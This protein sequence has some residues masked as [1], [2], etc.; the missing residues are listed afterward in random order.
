PKK[1]SEPEGTETAD[2]PLRYMIIFPC[3]RTSPDR[4]RAGT[5]LQAPAGQQ[6]PAE[7]PNVCFSKTRR[8]RTGRTPFVWDCKGRKHFRTRKIYFEISRKKK[9]A[10]KNQNKKPK[11]EKEQPL[12]PERGAKVER[13][14]LFT[15]PF[16]QKIYSNTDYQRLYFLLLD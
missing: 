11:T 4:H 14:F 16:S 6:C 9:Q 3:L 7:A 8:R 12:K 13:I 2:L 1:K 15:K 5:Y 10:S